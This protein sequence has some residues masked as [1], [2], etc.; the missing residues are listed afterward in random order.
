MKS[1]T[2]FCNTGFSPSIKIGSVVFSMCRC[3]HYVFKIRRREESRLKLSNNRKQ[4]SLAR[5]R[6]CLLTADF[7]ASHEKLKR[8]ALLFVVDWFLSIWP[9]LASPR[10]PQTF[11]P[12]RIHTCR[13]PDL[14]ANTWM[15]VRHSSFNLLHERENIITSLTL[16]AQ[17][18]RQ[19]LNMKPTTSSPCCCRCYS[20]RHTFFLNERHRNN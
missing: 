9:S 6:R 4:E 2:V 20:P 1:N 17:S 12:A 7:K 16:G 14:H 11:S 18:W 8:R 3:L 5:L 15:S 19:T 13:R 10:L